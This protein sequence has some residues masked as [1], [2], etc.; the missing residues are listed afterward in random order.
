MTDSSSLNVTI[1]DIAESK[2][3]ILGMHQ[4]LPDAAIRDAAIRRL[5]D[6]REN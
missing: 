4:R 6:K 3:S 1:K 5:Q 2:D